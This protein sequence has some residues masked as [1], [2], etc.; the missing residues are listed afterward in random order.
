MVRFIEAFPNLISSLPLSLLATNWKWKAGKPTPTVRS[1]SET[2][3]CSFLL[4]VANLQTVIITQLKPTCDDVK[5]TATDDKTTTPENMPVTII[6]LDNDIPAVT[7]TTLV[8]T[9]LLFLGLNGKCVLNLDGTV[10]YTPNTSYNGVDTCVYEV[11]DD[12][13]NCDTATIVITTIPSGEVPVANDDIITTDKNTPID[14][15]PLDNDDAVDGHPLKLQ[16]IVQGGDH[17]ECVKVSNTTVLYIPDQ[18]FVGQDT[19]VYNTCDDRKMCDTANIFITV[20]GEPEPC[21]EV[22]NESVI[23]PTKM[24]SNLQMN[25]CRICRAPR[26]TTDFAAPLNKL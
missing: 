10:I 11:C 5:V 21:D 16:N 18:N 14:I 19:C 6:V 4:F 25:L 15:F 2:L 22:T 7:G 9:T 17:G 20:T 23:S 26:T 24:V 3:A 13:G 1:L 8:V 12:L